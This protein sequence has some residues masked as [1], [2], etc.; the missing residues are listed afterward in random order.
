MISAFSPL[1]PFSCGS[2]LSG[3]YI[4][5]EGHYWIGMD[6]SPAMLGEQALLLCHPGLTSEV[7]PK[8][9]LVA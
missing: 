6:I 7:V 1:P 2:G 9:E 3:D 5:D 8:G 4:S